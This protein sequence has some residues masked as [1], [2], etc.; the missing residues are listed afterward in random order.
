MAGGVELF[1]RVAFLY[2]SLFLWVTAADQPVDAIVSECQDRYFCVS[3]DRGFAGQ[4][5]SFNVI[6]EQETQR[7]DAPY[8]AQCG[9]TYSTLTLAGRLIF[10]ASFFACNVK[11]VDDQTFTLS[12]Q[13]VTRDESGRETVFPSAIT[14]SLVLPWKPREVVCE[15]NY[16]EVSVRRNVPLIDQEDPIML[17]DATLGFQGPGD[18]T[19]TW[20]ISFRKL[21]IP[22]QIMNVTYARSLGYVVDS[23]SSRAVFRSAYNKSKTEILK[24]DGVTVEA[25][26]ATIFFQ[27]KWMLILIDVSAAC[28]KDPGTFDGAY[29]IWSTPRIMLPLVQDPS[30]FEDKS[31]GMGLDGQLLGSSTMNQRGYKLELVEQLLQISIPYGAVGGYLESCVIDNHYN[32]RYSI[33]LFFEHLWADDQY[34]VTQHCMFVPVST[35]FIPQTPFTID[36]K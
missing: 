18:A 33:D 32:Q 17:Q 15:E 34:E 3:V 20:Q 35:P 6:G 31:I 14:C 9:F 25:I 26:D 5:Y 1:V 21:G 24:V 10:R 12:Y 23:T 16:M 11:N 19:A 27:Q 36:R 13:L 29:L 4:D 22:E 28:T 8:A 7:V 30:S 2:A